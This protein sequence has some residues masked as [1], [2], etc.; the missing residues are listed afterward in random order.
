MLLHR[1]GYLGL[2]AVLDPIALL[3]RKE[4]DATELPVRVYTDMCA[5]LFHTGHVNYLKQCK[6]IHPD[7]H[8]IVGLHNDKTIQ[9]QPTELPFEATAMG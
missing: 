2:G 1:Y 3:Y 6:D 8:L 5:D 4:L 9:V 7:I